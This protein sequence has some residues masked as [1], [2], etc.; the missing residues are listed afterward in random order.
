MAALVLADVVD[1]TQLHASVGDEV[2]RRLWAEH[3]RG[4]RTALR[5]WHGREVGRSDG[6]LLM[7]DSCDDALHFAFDYH[8][9]LAAMEVPF[10]ARVG[11][12][13]GPVV[14][15]ENSAADV[16]GGATPFEIDGLAL[17]T[18]A[19]VMSVA[20]GGQTLLSQAAMQVLSGAAVRELQ[21]HAHGHWRLKGL[22]EPVALFEVA[23]PEPASTPPPDSPKA[24][25]VFQRGGLWLPVHELPNNLGPEPD[26]FIGRDD[27][28]RALARCFEDGARLVSLLGMGGIGKTR[29]AQRYAR[30]WLGSHPG[31]AW[32]CDL[33]AARSSDGIALAIAQALDLPLGQAD[34]VQQLTTALAARGECLLVLDNF[35]QVA[36]CA[37]A[38]LGVWLHALPLARF[39]VTSREVLGLA[40]E[41][42]QV[43]APMSPEEAQAM[44]LQRMQAA[45]LEAQLGAADAAALPQLVALLDQLPLAI[46]LAAARARIVPPA[47]QVLRMGERF[48]LLA[49]R[50]GRH[51]RQAT[52]RATLDWSWDLLMPPERAALA[53]LSVF[54]GGFTLASAEAV[55]DLAPFDDAPWVADVLQS[56]VEKSLV[57]RLHARRFD[58]L[59]TVQDYAIERLLA[60]DD[61]TWRRHWQHF[62]R[63]SEA[64]AVAGRGVEID[65][66]VAA[67]RRALAVEGS[68]AAECA[69]G[70]L[71]NGWA[72]L[73]LA[74][75]F[76]AALE[77]AQPL[78]KREALSDWQRAR[79][80]RVLGAA[81]ELLGQSDAAREHYATGLAIA[82]K[83]G[84]S[85]LQA[86]LQ[87]LLVALDVRRG[88][89]ADAERALAA[90]MQLAPQDPVVRLMAFSAR[91]RLELARAN[92]KQAELHF[93]QALP[94][95]QQLGDRR[96]EGGLLGN[97]G[98]CASMQGQLQQARD[99]FEQ[100][101]RVASELGDRQWAGNAHCNLGLVLHELGEHAAA[102]HE[103]EAAI[104]LAAALGHRRTEATALCNL[105][106]ALQS[107]GNPSA[108][109]ERH[110]QAVSAAQA[111]SDRRLEGQLRGYLGEQLAITGL[112]D[113]AWTCIGLAQSLLE[114]I[115]D[116]HDLA[117]LASQQA[118]CAILLGDDERALKALANA[119][120]QAAQLA[121]AVKSELGLT[122]ARARSA[123]SS[124]RS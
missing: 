12:H 70:A 8:R 53:Q 49:G 112:A 23:P 26:A 95:A 77:L 90:A 66:L 117:L 64:E 100:A 108:S 119:E 123:L 59:R 11:V 35:E 72:V 65:N 68:D 38:T 98:N 82:G 62:A 103:L 55:V 14:L 109:L 115:G 3:D 124:H 74:G 21:V 48:R 88:V 10:S 47:D 20:Q 122:L 63:M 39:I 116:V 96:W 36:R 118:L 7:F 69:V 44:F 43:L 31:G 91:G 2:A 5:P 37:E 80:L 71:V 110:R 29:L 67:C 57:R 45:G 54:E 93:L 104:Q 34:P 19:R 101:L 13:W 32:F 51:D 17:P 106:L 81:E 28:L 94:V 107:M 27:A 83:A 46:E 121:V 41:Q 105:G 30:G 76:R 16:A 40:G 111:L 4:A 15:R 25:R 79:V 1:S 99:H 42:V 87:C 97:L 113:E 85:A 102:C 114:S 6:F 92:P 84:Q 58:L 73:R 75:P 89:V 61:G 120:H 33:S 24:Y 86:Q 50:G 56:L 60:V 78:A 52:L 9:A 22:D 18:A